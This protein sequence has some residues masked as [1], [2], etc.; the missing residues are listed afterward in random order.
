MSTVMTRLALVVLCGMAAA[1]YWVA[2]LAGLMGAFGDPVLSMLGGAILAPALFLLIQTP[3]T[4]LSRMAGLVLAIVPVAALLVV[5]LRAEE[6]PV[7]LARFAAWPLL[8]SA[9]SAG[10]TLILLAAAEGRAV[11]PGPLFPLGAAALVTGMGVAETLALPTAMLLK[12]PL[13]LALALL[14]AALM[15]GLLLVLL[16]RSLPL[17]HERVLRA[18]IGLLPLLGFTGTILGIMGALSSLPDIFADSGS[19]DALPALLTG[20]GTAFETT[21]IG[22]VLAIAASFIL[23]LLSDMLAED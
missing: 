5:L 7:L 20:L 2:Y 16:A 17:R 6:L 12:T 14:G 8:L 4:V 23:T 21:L 9:V 11:T 13:H 3:P 19:V 15:T 22:L 1:G 10:L 18:L